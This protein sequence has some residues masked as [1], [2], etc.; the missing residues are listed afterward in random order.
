M[1]TQIKTILQSIASLTIGGLT[2]K[3]I[4]EIPVDCT[5][6]APIM[7]PEPM[8]GTI[9]NF[10]PTRQSFGGGGA[11]LLDIDYDIYYTF[12]FAPAGSGRS[13]LEYYGEA[14]EMWADIVET[15]LEND[16]ITGAVDMDIADTPNF[17]PIPDP[18]GNMFI[19][20][21]IVLHIKEFAK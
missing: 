7:Y 3:D 8:P 20:C 16:D 4:D 11:H 1:E 5:R 14:V 2:I 13:G 17:G 6:L 12:L 19:G 21:N 18:A 10:T 9:R 15:L